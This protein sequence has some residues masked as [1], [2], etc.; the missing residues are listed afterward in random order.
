MMNVL[1]T[2]ELEGSSSGANDDSYDNY[3]IKTN[4]IEK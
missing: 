4:Q 2:K 1:I 3:I